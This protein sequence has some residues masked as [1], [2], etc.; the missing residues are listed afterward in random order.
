MEGVEP[1]DQQEQDGSPH[2]RGRVQDQPLTLALLKE[3]LA[4]ERHADREHLAQSLEQVQGD[5]RAIRGRVD[6]VEQGVTSQMHKTMQMLN[7]ITDNYDAQARSLEELKEA[8]REFEQRLKTVESRPVASSTPGSTADT[9]AGGRQPALIIG[10]WNPDQA[11]EQTLQAA[12]DIL[13][14]LD[15]PLNAEDLFVPG[16]RRG[17]AILPIKGRP[18]ETEEAKRGHVQQAIQR[19]RNANVTTGSNEAGGMRKLWIALSQSPERRKRAKLAGKVKR[20]ILELG[21]EARLMEV[22][23][24]TGSV[25]LGGTKGSSAT[26]EQPKSAEK[27][28]AGWVD[29]T[30]LAKALKKPVKEVQA[31]WELRKAELL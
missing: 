21:G 23:F 5:V 4:Q 30:M 26:A 24:A 9:D 27:A 7:K 2:K 3:V 28:G 31:V 20:T 6:S 16:L 8:Q 11:A 29:V 12:K 19:V 18:F 25:W 17:Y 10:G 1:S 22:E 14:R 15:V 13:R